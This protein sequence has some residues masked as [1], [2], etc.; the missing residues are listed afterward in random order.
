MRS[1]GSTNLKLASLGLSVLLG[2]IAW[3]VAYNAVAAPAAPANIKAFMIATVGPSTQPIWDKSYADKLTDQDWDDVRKAAT[4]LTTAVSTVSA[5]GPVPEE[6][7]RAK[8][9]VWEDWTK[10]MSGAANAAKAAADKKDQMGLAMAGDD[11]VDICS[12]C[13]MAFDPTAK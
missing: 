11:L 3:A 2:T 9:P 1:A 7:G 5:G 10:K 6:Q 13:H 8:T 4:D 12:G